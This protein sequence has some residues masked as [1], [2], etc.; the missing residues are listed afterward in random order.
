MK[1][2]H[3]STL[4]RIAQASKQPRPVGRRMDGHTGDR[5]AEC[6]AVIKTHCRAA[7]RCGAV[8]RSLRSGLLV[9]AA[10]AK[11]AH[12]RGRK[13]PVVAGV[14]AQEGR[15]GQR[16]GARAVDSSV[17]LNLTIDLLGKIH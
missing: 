14:W 6:D 13:G 10:A 3:K 7:E 1:R 11:A 5:A 9:Q 4:F 17:V 12:H 8:W 15:T 2:A 16:R